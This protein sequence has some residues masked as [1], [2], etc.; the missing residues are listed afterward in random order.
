MNYYIL[1]LFEEYR[2]VGELLA[3]GLM[4]TLPSIKRRSNF[5]LKSILGAICCFAFVSLFIFV[6][7]LTYYVRDQAYSITIHI[8]W[9]TIVVIIVTIYMAFCF[10][11]NA[12]ELFWLMILVYSMQHIEYVL[13]NELLFMGL[14]VELSRNFFAYVSI[15]I[16]S[17]AALY[18]LFYKIFIP[19]I[20]GRDHF[21]I[22]DSTKT[23]VIYIVLFAFFV[24]ITFVNQHIARNTNMRLNYLGVFT[25]LANCLL[26]L[27]MQYNILRAA[28]LYLE[29][30]E[31]VRMYDNATK[32]YENF[33][34]SVDYVNIKCHDIKH[35]IRRLQ[36][37]GKLSP[38]KIDGLNDSVRIYESFVSTGNKTLDMVLTDKYVNCASQDITFSFMAD[39]KRL[40]G[41]EESD[42]YA[43]FSNM[44][45]NAVEYVEKTADKQKR[46]IKLFIKPKGNMLHIHQENFFEGKLEFSEGLPQ[47]TKENK[48]HHGFG[49]KSMQEITERYGGKLRINTADNIFKLD[50]LLPR[51][52]GK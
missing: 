25:D 43:L 31:A 5:A 19:N 13:I 33:K 8:V 39:A 23:R 44:L 47:T 48:L 51:G 17:C 27:V 42:I 20:R 35:E 14:A 41:M 26:A 24:G 3:A 2:H 29:K 4:L 21:T 7:Q 45:D 40:E 36:R 28:K 22:E 15:C 11:L 34:K 50:I 46:Y 32:L 6:R 10:K 16:V 52:K 12:S 1:L 18:Y 37:E 9:Y 30:I 49:V 38:E